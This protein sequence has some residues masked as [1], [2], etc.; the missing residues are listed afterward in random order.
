MQPSVHVKDKFFNPLHFQDCFGTSANFFHQKQNQLYTVTWSCQRYFK[1]L[2]RTISNPDFRRRCQEERANQIGHPYM[3]L[4]VPEIC[5]LSTKKPTVFN[6]SGLQLAHAKIYGPRITK[7]P[8]MEVD[9]VK[10]TR[11]SLPSAL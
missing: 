10:D 8:S 3:S 1:K 7:K 11:A 6:F 9:S 5:P 2:F 4:M